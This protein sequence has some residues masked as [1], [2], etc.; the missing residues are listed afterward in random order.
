MNTNCLEVRSSRSL[1]PLRKCWLHVNAHSTKEKK[2][3]PKCCCNLTTTHAHKINIFHENKDGNDVQPF[4]HIRKS[5]KS[6]RRAFIYSFQSL[7][8]SR[9]EVWLVGYSVRSLLVLYRA[10]GRCQTDDWNIRCSRL[11]NRSFG[12]NENV[13][14]WC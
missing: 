5:A 9:N 4:H 2:K 10:K 11:T 1:P 3:E 13:G 6:S 12:K 14:F 8:V 7:L